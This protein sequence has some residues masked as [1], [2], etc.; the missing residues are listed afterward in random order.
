MMVQQERERQSLQESVGDLKS[1][2]KSLSLRVVMRP[3]N[4]V[5]IPRV[6][7]LTQ[8]TNQFN[9]SLKRRSIL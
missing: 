2:L 4:E 5:D 6:A 1:Y 3:A 9:L 8:K 7:Q